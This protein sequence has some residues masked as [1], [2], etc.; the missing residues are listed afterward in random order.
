MDT[1]PKSNS[2]Y[3]FG[4]YQVDAAAGQIRKHGVRLRLAGQPFE[5]L[6]MLLER[7]GQVVTRD[8][9]Q[10]RLWS[11]ETFVDFENSLNKAINKLRQALA[12]SPEKP[13]Y[14][15][16][17]PRRGYRFL[18]Q[19]QK[20]QQGSAFLEDSA[21]LVRR[22]GSKTGGA[23][24]LSNRARSRRGLVAAAV[25]GFLLLAG[26]WILARPQANPRVL[27]ATALTRAS[28][29]DAFGRIET[30]GV[31]L[32]FLQRRGHRWELSQMPASGGEVQPF[33]TPFQNAKIM[34]VSPDAS[35]I[36]VAS[37]ESRSDP[38]PL[39]IMPS[40]GGAPRRL[41]QVFA[42]DATFTP[43]GSKVT[44]CTEEGVFEIGRDGINVK[45][46]TD[47]AGIKGGL[48]W[49]PDGKVLRFDLIARQQ[50]R[51][52]IWE[53]DAD[54][55]NL[56]EALKGWDEV[57]VQCCGR[58]TRNGKYYVFLGFAE[59][60]APSVWAWRERR[61]FWFRHEVPVRLSAG[62]LM[63]RAPITSPDNQHLYVLGNNQ[64]TEYVRFDAKTREF[65]SL[66]EGQD[67]SWISFATRGDFTVYRG[68]DDA[69]W[70]SRADG[71]ERRKLVGTALQPAMPAVRPG[72]R[73][74]AFRGVPVGSAKSRIFAV[75]MEGG[76]ASEIVAENFSVD[77]P[78]WSPD[79]SKLL[80]EVDSET[81]TSAGLYLLDWK[82]RQK[83]K[84]P[85]S[86]GYW[87]S[88]WSPDGKYL[89]SNS[90]D[91][92]R[93][94]IF[95]WRNKEWSEVARGNTF[96]PVAWSR[97]SQF[98][99]YQDLLEEDEPVRR[100]RI[101]DRK[102]D[103]A[104][105]CRPLLEGGVQRCG[106]EDVMPDGSIVLQLTRGDQDVYALDIDLP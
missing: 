35:E 96:G 20:A 51:T 82:T 65:R 106:F 1:N 103:R 69:L 36:I 61:R 3:Q 49:S 95:D 60:G 87:K 102:V 27:K 90:E 12:D 101:A 94:V 98:L 52:T 45:K 38:L 34:A 19:V 85:D 100:M 74:I 42:S 41:G 89:A 43:D 93:I 92:K 81:G 54:G 64:H 71:G 40:V 53:V 73:E 33:V 72:G 2:T 105:E 68:P 37:F 5:I 18:A 63:M 31:R 30:D 29:A 22:E 83:E 58:W 11:R 76:E 44:Y 77:V 59:N 57:P 32:F 23:D 17:L 6:L 47:I 14:V 48:S 75:S 62:P 21:V 99:Y 24:S 66:L 97:D 56:H 8:E 84:I 15:E 88:R 104:V 13:T 4:P 16:T 46:L 7:A 79:G 78:T 26:T 10:E 9:I 67:G 50:T 91:Q 28:R 86:E 25:A 55:G 70:S 39:W 80:Y